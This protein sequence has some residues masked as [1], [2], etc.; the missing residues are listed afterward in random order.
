M[1]PID[2]ESQMLRMLDGDLSAEEVAELDKILTESPESRETWRRTSLIHSKLEV[3]FAAKKGIAESTPVPIKRVMEEQRRKVVRFSVF[4]TAA[5]LVIMAAVLWIINA[6]NDGKRLATFKT[7]S[8]STFSLVHSTESKPP[9]GN[10]M[11]KGST[12]IVQHGVTEILLP[13][14][15]RAVVEGPASLTLEDDR[16]LQF[17]QGRGFFEITTERGKGFTVITPQQ[18]IVDLGTSFGVVVRGGDVEVDLHVL[19]GHVRVDAPDGSE[20][21]VLQAPRSVS[22]DGNQVG[23]KITRA[24]F[25]SMLPEKIETIF[26]EDFEYGLVS[27]HRY[28]VSIEP[29]IVTNLKGAGFAGISADKPWIF[30]ASSSVPDSILVGNPGFEAGRVKLERGKAIPSWHVSS[31]NY[32][33]WGTEKMRNGILPTEGEFFGRVFLRRWLKQELSE[34]IIAGTTYV[35]TVDCGV[36]LNSLVNI[37]LWGS[38]AGPEIALAEGVIHPGKNGWIKD[39]HILFSATEKHATGQTLGISLGCESGDFAAFDDV[40]MGKVGHQSQVIPVPYRSTTDLNT[41]PRIVSLSPEL[42]SV[43]SSPSKVLRVEFDQVIQVGKG[44]VIIRDESSDVETV[45]IAGSSHLNFEDNVLKFLPKMALKDSEA[46]MGHLSGW[47]TDTW[48]GTFNPSGNG[49]WY[50]EQMLADE[51]DLEGA[52]TTMRG[53]IMATIHPDPLGKG[54]RREVGAIKADTHYNVTMAIGVRSD[55]ITELARFAGYKLRLCSGSTVLS[56]ISSNAPPGPPGSIKKVSFSWNSSSLPEGISPGDPLTLEIAAGAGTEGYLD[57]DSI[58][59]SSL[60]QPKLEVNV[61]K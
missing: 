13:N 19:E 56:E 54:I 31:K 41:P 28:S 34:P 52:L 38:D 2:L 27:D 21:E 50:H 18:R 43:N 42:N 32:Y 35:L 15:V 20:G 44:R 25:L 16:T 49:R 8:G 57:L 7:S 39:V 40:R 22:L 61:K 30:S 1:N 10:T 24:G 58:R 47:Q 36:S 6:P 26:E 3:L 53:P 4:S 11:I 60:A 33:G 17:D 46:S 5:A 23:T 45:L 14:D 51:S 29:S 55:N 37:R 59:I 9:I 12:L 48:V